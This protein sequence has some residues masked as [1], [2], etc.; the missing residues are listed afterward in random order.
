MFGLSDLKQTRVYQEGRQE[1][2]RQEKLRM[3][4]LLL[5]LGLSTEE[6][7]KELDL[8]LEDVQQQIQKQATS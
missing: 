8:C 7:A 3:I 2:V 1:G 5:K 6:I 4:P